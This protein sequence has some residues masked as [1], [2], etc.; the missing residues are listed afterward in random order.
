MKSKMEIFKLEDRVLFEAAAVAEIVE[1]MENSPNANMNENDRQAQEEKDAVKNV[2]VENATAAPQAEAKQPDKVAD[3]DAEIQKLID[4]DIAFSGIGSEVVGD[5]IN[6]LINDFGADAVEDTI[7]D[8]MKS[9]AA[10]TDISLS[11]EYTTGNRE[12]IVINSSVQDADQIIASLDSNQEVLI[13]ESDKDAMAQINDYLEAAGAEFSAIHIVSHGNAGYITLAGERYD[14][15][16]F[17]AEVWMSIGSYL[18]DDGDILFYSCNLAADEAGQDFIAMVAEAS[19]ADVAASTDNTGLSGNWDLEYAIGNIEA[20]SIAVSEYNHNLYGVGSESALQFAL[21][22]GETSITIENDFTISDGITI[23]TTDAIK[24]TGDGYTLTWDGDLGGVM[25]KTVNG[26]DVTFSDITLNGAS[27]FVDSWTPVTQGA[28][29]IVIGDGGGGGGKLTLTDVTMR[30]GYASYSSLGGGAIYTTGDITL[31]ITGGSFSNNTAENDGG[32]IYVSTE[33]TTMIIEDVDFTENASVWG[34]GGAIAVTSWGEVD[35]DITGGEFKKN[36]AMY[37]GGAIN[38]YNEYGSSIKLTVDGSTFSG[39]E[40]GWDGGAIYANAAGCSIIVDIDGDFTA[41]KAGVN[42]VNIQG[43]GGAVY[44]EGSNSMGAAEVNIGGTYTGNTA[45]VYGGAVHVHVDGNN[46]ELTVETGSEFDGNKAGWDGGAICVNASWGSI[47][48]D[49]DGKFTGNSTTLN[50]NG[51][52]IFLTSDFDPITANISGEFSNNV[53]TNGGGGA[54]GIKAATAV[55]LTVEESKFEGNKALASIGGAIAV[56]DF[57]SGI[58]KIGTESVVDFIGN[59]TPLNGGAV[60]VAG[61]LINMEVGGDSGKVTFIR[62]EAS[63]SIDRE[64][65]GNGGAIYTLSGSTRSMITI[66]N[67]IFG[68]STGQNSQGNMAKH[69]GGA[70]WSSGYGSFVILNSSFAGNNAGLDGGSI[71]VTKNSIININSGTTFSIGQDSK[72]KAGRNGGAIFISAGATVNVNTD[73]AFSN[74]KAGNDGGAVYIDGGTLNLNTA[75]TFSNNEAV[76]NGGAIHV[77][78]GTLNMA[79]T[80]LVNNNTAANNGGGIYLGNGSNMQLSGNGSQISGNIAARDGGGIY[81]AKGSLTNV[82]LENGEIFNNYAGTSVTGSSAYSGLGGNGGGLWMSGT[83]TI[84]TNGVQI[85][86]N[87]ARG[88][89]A[90]STTEGYGGGIYASDGSNITVNNG[91]IGGSVGLANTAVY[92]GGVYMAANGYM[93]IT[94][95]EISYNNATNG[96]GIYVKSG[97]VEMSGGSVDSHNV[98]GNG[99]GIYVS[100]ISSSVTMSGTASVNSNTAAGNGGGIYV[101]ADGLMKIAGGTVG[102]SGNANTASA[103]GGVYMNTGGSLNMTGGEVS[104][105]IVTG[106]DGGGI[107]VKSGTVEMSGGSVS[108]H[109]VSGNG[110]GIYVS[111]TGSSVTIGGSFSLNKAGGSGGAVYAESALTINNGNFS[112]NEANFQ[113]GAIFTSENMTITD[114]GFTENTSS[115]GGAIYA[116]TTL[117]ILISGSNFTENTATGIGMGG[118][119]IALHCGPN[120]TITNSTFTGN[121]SA[122]RGGAIYSNSGSINGVVYPD[123]TIKITDSVFTGNTSVDSGGAIFAQSTALIIHAGAIGTAFTDNVAKAS[124]GAIYAGPEVPLT[125]YAGDSSSGTRGATFTDNRAAA[126]GGA[127]AAFRATMIDGATFVYTRSDAAATDGGAIYYGQS[128]IA[129]MPFNI[130]VKNSTFSNFYASNVGG[131]IYS[132]GQLILEGGEFTNNRAGLYGGGIYHVNSS[133]SYLSTIDGA[134]FKYTLT[135]NAAAYGGGIFTHSSLLTVTNSSFNNL[136]ANYGGAIYAGTALTIGSGVSFTGNIA[137]NYGGG[138]YNVAALTVGAGT[139]FTGNKAGYGGAIASYTTAAAGTALNIGDNVTF[140]DNSATNTGGGIWIRATVG[141]VNLTIGNNVQFNGNVGGTNGGAIYAYADASTITMSI[142]EGGTFGTNTATT[143]DGGAI[144]AYAA[145]STATLTVGSGT[146]FMNNEAGARGGAI[147]FAGSNAA[148]TTVNIGSAGGADVVL[149]G[150]KALG[151]DGG[152]IWGRGAL[153]LNNVYF[154]GNSAGGNGGAIYGGTTIDITMNG[155]S[156]GGAT[157]SQGNSAANGGAIYATAALTLSDSIFINNTAT[158][159]GGAVYGKA[160]LTIG[161][162]VSFSKNSAT[163]RGGAVYAESA[164]TIN[165]G[166]FTGNNAQA[167]G[168]AIYS[169]SDLTVSGNSTFN[170]NYVSHTKTS[171]AVYGGAIYAGADLTVTGKAVFDGN[172]LMTGNGPESYGGAIYVVGKGDIAEA[173]FKNNESRLNADGFAVGH[174]GAIYSEADLTVKNSKFDNNRSDYGGAIYIRQND[175]STM[176]VSISNSEFNDNRARINGGAIY[177]SSA[178]LNL[179]AGNMFNGGFAGNNG[180]LIYSAGTLKINAA[181]TFENGEAGNQGGALYLANGSTFSQA[182]SLVFINNQAGVD[183]G[184]IYSQIDLTIYGTFTENQALN[185]KGGAIYGEKDVTVSG[186]KFTSNKAELSGG[187]IYAAGDVDSSKNEYTGNIAVSGNSGGGIYTAA[188][189]N[190]ANDKFSGNQAQAGSGGAFYAGGNAEITHSEFRQNTAKVDG[191]AVYVGGVSANMD[192]TLIADN[193]AT[194]DGGGI[195]FADTAVVAVLLNLTIAN[196]TAANGG[197]IYAAMSAGTIYNN[198]AVKNSILWGNKAN[199]QPDQYVGLNSGNFSNSGIE[200]WGGGGTNNIALQAT[201][202][203]TNK[204]GEYYV[205]FEYENTDAVLDRSYH[206]AQG[207]YAI[208]RGDNTPYVGVTDPTDLANN[209]RIYGG[210]NGGIVDMGAYES[211]H[212]G[213]VVVTATGDTVKYG[214]TGTVSATNDGA[215]SG[216]YTY[217]M[218]PN[219]YVSLNGNQAL[220]TKAGGTVTVTTDFISTDGLWEGSAEAK[221]TTTVRELV[222]V[223]QGGTYDYNGAY[224]AFTWEESKTKGDGL[225]TVFG[226]TVTSYDDVKHRN[227]GDYTLDNLNIQIGANG[228]K[229]SNYDIKY[230]DG[231]MKINAIAVTVTRDANDRTYDGTTDATENSAI[232]SGVLGNDEVW[233]NQAGAE[234]ANKNAGDNKALIFKDGTLGGG[235]AGNYYIVYVNDTANIAQAQVTVTRD[236]ADRTYDGTT[237]ATENSA[238]S[239]GVLGG[240]EVWYNQAGAKF[241]DKNAGLNKT[242]IYEDGTLSGG[243]AGNYYI[244]YADDTANIA[245]AQVTVTRDAADRTYD[246]TTNATENSVISSGVLGGDEVWYNQAGA[247][248]ANKNAGLNK[249]VIYEDGTLSGEDAGN[250]YIVYVNDTADIAQAQ[251]TV[252]RDAADKTYDSTTNATENS[253]V[254]EGV[255]GGDEVWYNQAGAEFANKNAGDN[256]AL[257]FK[258]GTL[259]GG[260]AGNYYIVYVNDTA[261]IAQAQV[262]VTRDAADKTY[263][264]TTN[265]TENSVVTEGVLGGDEVWYNQAGAEFANKNA[266]DNKTLIF[267]DGTLGGEDAGN[268]YIVYVNDTAD[269]AQAQVTV[270]RDAADKTYDSTTNATENSVVTEGVLGGDE[271]WYNQAGAEFAN[272]NAGDNKTLI[273]KDG[274]LGGEDAGNYYIVYVNDTA[275]IAQAQVTVTRDAADKTYDSTTNATENSVITDGVFDDDD[276]SYNMAGAEFADKNAGL[277]KTVIYEDGTLSGEDAGN[278]YIVYA[279]DTAD[280]AQ[281]QVTVT[282]DAADKTY[283]STT[284]AT[285]NSVITDGVFDDDDVSYNM[286][287]AEFADK[288]AGLNKTVIYEDGTLSGEDAGNYYIVYA[289]DTADIAQAQVTVTRDAADKTYDGTTDATENSVITDGVFGN[290]DV[291]YNMAGAEFADKNAGLNKTVIYEDGT[292]SGGD[293]GNYYIVYANDTADIDKASLIIVIDDKTKAAGEVD[294]KFTGTATG[295]VGSDTV[296]NYNRTDKSETEGQHA[297][298]QYQLNTDNSD[299]YD[300]TV[301]NGTLTITG[302]ARIN[303][304]SDASSRRYVINGQHEANLINQVLSNTANRDA[305]AVLDTETSGDHHAASHQTT[306]KASNKLKSNLRENSQKKAFEEI[307]QQMVQQR[308]SNALKTDMFS[309]K[310]EKTSIVES[311]YKSDGKNSNARVQVPTSEYSSSQNTSF[312]SDHPMHTMPSQISIDASGIHEVNFGSVDLT[313]VTV[314]EKAENFKDKLDIILDEML[315]V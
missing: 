37:S 7:H 16:N 276:V 267:K 222:I 307:D 281:A 159:N 89:D 93:K 296:S 227:A 55:T 122:Y 10:Q 132:V 308:T 8:A 232:S 306:A 245:Q 80:T 248:F 102:G 229:N 207:S 157:A 88:K 120:V 313:N 249:T 14:A 289:N 87:T 186:S 70:I 259:G 62:N 153:T 239:S 19:N 215:V 40:A 129:S 130:T 76:N 169:D 262:T 139:Q 266:G 288:N 141:S 84:S 135:S 69:D 201:N 92:G 243:D 175:D 118:G 13:P 79:G 283:D 99:G 72:G 233:Y 101:D 48:A 174:G 237:N 280:I 137:A 193:T 286:A 125:I 198:V 38:V 155:G 314:M 85:Y 149:E 25:F 180:G 136:R 43:S 115:A 3:I 148:N 151:G 41:N 94:G 181:M 284:N 26:A 165:N 6:S 246:G 209:D 73:M 236:A 255:L 33:N 298:D 228:E 152:A 191:G 142:G 96:G 185:S 123:G 39:N 17:D 67:S 242:V 301:H 247:E 162:N 138:I 304:Y 206:L 58:I 204:A 63:S 28:Q 251:V 53:A 167:M 86:S 31:N 60:Y 183:G 234:F 218:T 208:N 250:Y 225:A 265:A 5:A 51:G 274:T 235:D 212:R 163:G 56:Y 124:G 147:L 4:G 312:E 131:A 49:I 21:D 164:L 171:G 113:G 214:N 269:I 200:G 291:S 107:Y 240:D 273:F 91:T 256:K 187:A 275:D 238:I 52:A 293:A 128:T 2:P 268:Y 279:N 27:D 194:G 168:G 161:D 110:A 297:I 190:I 54:I 34:K 271:V 146:N 253:V 46:V 202:K 230:V 59:S 257:I 112:K 104:H 261:D 117:D 144:Y 203:G 66:N 299:N 241:A 65:Y 224:H 182:D 78:T 292:L 310:S 83:L 195:Y 217:T 143:G 126:N 77:A 264:S 309:D 97:T 300:V 109:N 61:T 68:D 30:K 50:G 158:V 294:P 15:A 216:N 127:I 121:T 226:D 192:N 295:L 90:S 57:T 36:T 196:N 282:R 287:G 24:I 9:E 45:A 18:A 156:F 105:N 178:T 95:G 244:V 270:T 278:Y 140:E 199:G 305:D 12:L 219:D 223:I 106:G 179:N 303:I 100:G 231:A 75:T 32:A 1:A 23:S 285:E 29:I 221:V 22:N 108:N 263:D 210:I 103:G 254:T 150:N 44:V 213:S 166:S 71:Y 205:N 111:G 98:S 177:L 211:E 258:D 188:N 81:A 145:A 315:N 154:Y 290:D 173:E 82:T 116:N 277:N 311:Q 64:G 20:N 160:S 42:G 47:T 302:E 172:Y 220:A 184:A 170:G 189:V 252:T 133:N 272:K 176:S 197:G 119:A 35:I 114:S 74:F 260:D 134:V 11:D